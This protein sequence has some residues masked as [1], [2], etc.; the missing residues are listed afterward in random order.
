MKCLKGDDDLEIEHS[1]KC[2][3][4]KPCLRGCTKKICGD[5]GKTYC[6]QC[7]FD[8]AKCLDPSLSVAHEGKAM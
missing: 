1:G 7:L 2:D 8:N 5:D 4:K 6:N 3:C